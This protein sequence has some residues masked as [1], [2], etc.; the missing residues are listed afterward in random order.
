M[1]KLHLKVMRITYLRVWD[2]KSGQVP[3]YSRYGLGKP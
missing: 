3:E 1:L 2:I